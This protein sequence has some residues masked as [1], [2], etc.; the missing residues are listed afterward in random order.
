MRIS[1]NVFVEYFLNIVIVFYVMGRVPDVFKAFKKLILMTTL[2]Q[3]L[4]ATVMRFC[5][6]P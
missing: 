4:I 5:K 3:L 1:I 2:Y 6:P